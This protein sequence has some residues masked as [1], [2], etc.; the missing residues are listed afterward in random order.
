VLSDAK[1]LMEAHMEVRKKDGASEESLRVSWAAEM[2]E[3]CQG[4][5]LTRLIFNTD[6]L[7]D[8]EIE[9]L[10]VT[11]QK[12]RSEA[13]LRAQLAET[14]NG[15]GSLKQKQRGYSYAE[16]FYN[17]GL[18]IRKSL[19]EGDDHGKTKEQNIAQS[20]VSLGNLFLA[21]AAEEKT[22]DTPAAHERRIGLLDRA[23]EMLEKSKEAYIKGF[24][25]GHPKV[26]WAWEGM[27]NTFEK[28]G[29][30]REAQAAWTQAIAIRRNLQLKDNS[31]QMFTKELLANEEKVKQVSSKRTGI[32]E[33]LRTAGQLST[34]ASGQSK[35]GGLM[36]AVLKAGRSP[37]GKQGEASTDEASPSTTKP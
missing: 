20:L 35:G 2:A 6:R 25:D 11:A 8:A 14:F 31:K 1:Q 32:A 5:A 37:G 30:L 19:P 16:D 10:L 29:R 12:L 22:K 9:S 18:E 17:K 28:M 33:R 4:L 24:Y 3:V 15:L 36:K 13:G 27:G 34:F 21:M 26:A 7:E 23:L